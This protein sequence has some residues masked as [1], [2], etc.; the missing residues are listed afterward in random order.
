MI[1]DTFRRNGKTYTRISKTVARKLFNSGEKILFEPCIVY[2][3]SEWLSYIP[4]NY[5]NSM[6]DFD[7]LVIAYEYYN[8]IP[9]T[10]F[11]KIEED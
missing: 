10:V 5:D 9:Y 8:Q 1:K 3:P 7:S 2:R 11:Y 4:F 6:Q